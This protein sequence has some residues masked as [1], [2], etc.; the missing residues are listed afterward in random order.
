MAIAQMAKIL[1]ASHRT[2][3]SQLLEELQRRGIFHILNAEEA[4]L[5]RDFPEL[6]AST[7][8]PKDLET[9]V[10]RLEK[11]I[12]FLKTYAPAQK[13][14]A[15]VLA[16]RTVIDEKAYNKIISDSKTLKTIDKCE[17]IEASME[18]AKGQI[19]HLQCTLEML[20]PWAPLQTPVEQI[21]RLHKA[22]CWA[23]LIPNQQFEQTREKL[24]ESGA[25]IQQIAASNNKTACLIVALNENAEAIQKLLRSAEFEPVSFEP[26]RGTVT[27]LIAEHNEKL[28][29]A[30]Q[31][32][33][34]HNDNAA[35]LSQNLLNL[36]I[37]Y[38]HY[39]NLLEREQTKD[40][41]PAT[42]HTVILEGWVKKKDYARLEK[43]V[44]GFEASTLRK[45]EPVEDEEIP[46]EIE[47]K[48]AIKPFEVITRLYGMPKHF[49]VDPTV[50]LAPFLPCSSDCA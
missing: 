31:Q 4:I 32:L 35:K 15:G 37:L 25:A 40:T 7:E 49:E 28:H 39:K 43:L 22:T 47:N 16:P 2:Q 11:S 45:I 24:S 46:V 17:Q 13:G 10:N 36:G 41:A 30:Q 3:A 29:H 19:E 44:S 34:T 9:L 21:G 1:I 33:S 18:K 42:E 8:R 6:G 26:M 27:R 12:A 14:L 20:R 50:F 5:S 23:G 48:G 38:D